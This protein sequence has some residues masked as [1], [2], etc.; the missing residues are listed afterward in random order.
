[1]KCKY[2]PAYW[3]KITFDYKNM[4]VENCGCYCDPNI[5]YKTCVRENNNM[6]CN[7]KISYIE[8]VMKQVKKDIE[9]RFLLDSIIY[10][11]EQ[12]NL[13]NENEKNKF[14]LNPFKS[15]DLGIKNILHSFDEY[16][17]NLI[18]EGE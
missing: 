14:S 17:K 4:N 6:G 11:K 1:M 12:Y 3:E 10:L 8:K 2:C 16:K 18:K 15:I 13:L 5:K 7:R 9:L